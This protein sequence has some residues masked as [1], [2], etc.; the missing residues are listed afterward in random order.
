MTDDDM[1]DTLFLFQP[2]GLGT[3]WCFRMVTPAALVGRP[4]RRIGRP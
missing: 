3:G 2:R 4:N 1:L